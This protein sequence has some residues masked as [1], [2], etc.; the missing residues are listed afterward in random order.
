M[1]RYLKIGLLFLAFPFV[2]LFFLLVPPLGWIY[3]KM[4]T[5]FSGEKA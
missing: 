5:W 4:W 3:E 2:A 1:A